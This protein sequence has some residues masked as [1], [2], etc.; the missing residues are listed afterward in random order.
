MTNHMID[1]G[2]Y[3]FGKTVI[4]KRRWNGFLFINNIVMADA[5]YLIGGIPSNNMWSNHLQH[6]S[7]Q[8]SGNGGPSVS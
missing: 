2:A 7:C 6:F 3:R 1:R 5:V 4:V 8:S